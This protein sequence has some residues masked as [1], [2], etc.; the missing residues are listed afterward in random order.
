MKESVRVQPYATSCFAGF[1][2]ANTDPSV[3]VCRIEAS[4][5]TAS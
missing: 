3:V 5:G 4:R 1:K 2:T